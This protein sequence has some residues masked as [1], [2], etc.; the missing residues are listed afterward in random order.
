M[1]SYS[2]LEIIQTLGKVP[3]SLFTTVDFAR[4]FP[5]VKKNT[6]YGRIKRLKRARLIKE[7]IKGK[8]LVSSGKPNEFT[9]A[10]F[11]YQPSYI[12]L[13]SALSFYG[14]ITGF[15]FQ[16][17]SI[18]PR[19]TKLIKID[20]RE[21][22]Y[23]HIKPSLFWGLEKK[24]DFLIADKEKT[25]IDFLYYAYKGLKSLNM[26]EFDLSEIDRDRFIKYCNKITNGGFIN[27]IKK[28]KLP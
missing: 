1:E 25:L 17:N 19:K 27:F 22:Q 23:Y 28:I 14:V 21:Y 6:L 16:I 24:E 12:S 15:P 26:D 20:S 9:L 11:L 5:A 2:Q 10:N 7:L 4:L 8:Y 13:E 3:L 18:T